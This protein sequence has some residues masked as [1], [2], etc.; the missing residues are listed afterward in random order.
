MNP[1]GILKFQARGQLGPA[2]LIWLYQWTASITEPLKRDRGTW[3][4]DTRA[5]RTV[6]TTENC[7]GLGSYSITCRRPTNR[8]AYTHFLD[9]F[10]LLL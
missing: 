5:T 2:R 6:Q 9:C 3:H 7:S 10:E 1:R 8:A 4:K